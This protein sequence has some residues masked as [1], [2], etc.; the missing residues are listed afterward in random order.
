M[1]LIYCISNDINDKKYIG[2]TTQTLSERWKQ[3]K[4]CA[5]N[6]KLNEKRP[7]YWA[8]HKYGIEHFQ[9]N[10]IEDNISQNIL[11]EREKYWIKYYNSYFN[12]Y[13]GTIGG[14]GKNT[15]RIIEQY[16]LNGKLIN[17]F[18]DSQSACNTL[19]I[20]NSVLRGGCTHRYK[21][22]KGTILKYQDEDI[23]V[24]ELID[25]ANSINYKQTNVYQYNLDGTL[26]KIWNNAKEL[27]NSGLVSS[28]LWKKIDGP[29]PYN[30]YVWRRE[31]KT[32]YDNLDLTSIIVQLDQN[33]NIIGYYDSFANA[34]KALNKS[35]PSSISEACR[36]KEY[37]KTAY[38]YYWKY[39]ADILKEVNT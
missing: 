13:N 24:Q 23:S 21:T 31:N 7:L 18:E 2:L 27:I 22:V 36:Q 6:I 17:I 14:D 33:N 29:K 8:M 9:I 1:G 39:L 4:I 15:P 10:V 38:G 25:L 34:A 19:N 5:N 28:N 37:H 20:C 11:E 30:G 32:F 16:D 3:H 26:I 12:G 35:S